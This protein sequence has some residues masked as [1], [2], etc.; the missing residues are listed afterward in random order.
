MKLHLVACRPDVRIA[1]DQLQLRHGHIGCAQVPNQPFVRKPLHR[2][3]RLHKLLVDVPVRIR[4]AR[5]H[6]TPG[7]V[8]VPKRP[9]HQ[10]QI[11]VLEP[12]VPQRLPARCRYILR[13]VPVVP[14]LRRDPHLVPRRRPLQHMA[15]TLP[16]RRLIAIHR[17]AIEVTVPGPRR[18]S[19]C[20]RDAGRVYLVGPKRP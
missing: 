6:L 18:I 16:D 9:M 17:R 7:W 15:Q 13:R 3:P 20:S 4:A 1:Q 14:K 11:Q 19:Y 12:Q 8:E 2:T 10:I 5:R